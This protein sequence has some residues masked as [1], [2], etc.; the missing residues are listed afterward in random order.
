LAEAPTADIRA[1]PGG[2]ARFR[3]GAESAIEP[4]TAD[5]DVLNREIG[6]SLD[7]VAERGKKLE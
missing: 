7:V 3:L 2:G 5:V 1:S 6:A 4:T